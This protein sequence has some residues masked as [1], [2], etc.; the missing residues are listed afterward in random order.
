MRGAIRGHQRH[1]ELHLMRG[2]IGVDRL[3][4]LHLPVCT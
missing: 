2:A 4:E 3:L 1:L